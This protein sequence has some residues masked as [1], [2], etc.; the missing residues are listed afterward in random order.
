VEINFLTKEVSPKGAASKI[1]LK[2]IQYYRELVFF[3]ISNSG[4]DISKP[5]SFFMKLSYKPG[6]LN[7]YYVASVSIIYDGKE[8]SKSVLSSFS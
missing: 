5:T 7:R 1:F 3:E 2:T 8:F 6:D 4:L